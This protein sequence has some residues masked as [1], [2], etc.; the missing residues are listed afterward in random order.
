MLK[1]LSKPL[2]LLGTFLLFGATVAAAADIA[3]GSPLKFA[4][5]VA[6]FARIDAQQPSEP[7]GVVVTGSSSVRMW[8]PRIQRDLPGIRVIPRGFGG[9]NMNDLFFYSEQLISKYQP[10]AVAIYEGDNDIAQGIAPRQVADKFL[11]LGDKL[12]SENPDLR[13]YFIAIK[14]SL[15]R[16][17]LW[18][19][20]QQTNRLIE[21]LCDER[22][23]YF[24]IDVAGA[25]LENGRPKR[26]IFIGDGLHLNEKGYE[27]WAEAVAAVLEKL[28]RG[29]E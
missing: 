12:R 1:L 28:E 14:P 16:W 22:E 13:I 5:E 27:L 26:D 8:R 23:G 3:Y 21:A 11:A 9:S 24:Y 4:G 17:S 29:Y 19:K 7:G 2:A 25:L 6:N 18:P 15:A 20:M 10:R